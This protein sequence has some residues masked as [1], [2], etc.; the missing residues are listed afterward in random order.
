MMDNDCDEPYAGGIEIEN[1]KDFSIKAKTN[2]PGGSNSAVC[3]VC[4]NKDEK[5]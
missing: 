1:F 3:I 4:S 2:I 5:V